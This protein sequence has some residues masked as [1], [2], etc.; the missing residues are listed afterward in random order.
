MLQFRPIHLSDRPCI[1]S[2]VRPLKSRQLNYTF[3][4]LYLWRDACEFM[5]CEANDLLLIKT[6]YYCNHNY[7]FPVGNGD[8]SEAIERMIDYSQRHK[9]PFSMLKV[10]E[11][12][13]DYLFTHFPNR[14]MSV[15][16][17][18]DEEY[19]YLSERLASLQGKALQ[20]KRNHINALDKEHAWSFERIT[21]DN[22]AEVLAFNAWWVQQ[23]DT[24]SMPRSMEIE[25]EA[26]EQ[27]L[28]HYVELSS[29]DGGLLRIDGR[30]EGFS[31]GCKTFSDTYLTL[32][33]RA[34]S[35][36]RGAYPLLNREF[37]R[38]YAT[39][40]L[41]VNRGEDCGDEGLRRAKL[42]YHPDRMDKRYIISLRP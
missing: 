3:E 17:R 15:E 35:A 38:A 10:N 18:D 19:L 29:L 22:F 23:I 1:E 2:Y 12:Q 5:I 40:S 28:Q 13:R 42:S 9:C 27:A 25:H 33:E 16:D 11:A 39:E 4:V 36:L 24:T 6:F 14:F 21:A 37:A 31:I 32:F 41:Y 34:N 20:P 7:L 30:V 26:V 8:V